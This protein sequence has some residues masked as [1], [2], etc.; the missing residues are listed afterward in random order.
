M[1]SI[2]RARETGDRRRGYALLDVVLAVALFALTV[3]GLVSV[4]QRIN[5]TSSTFARDRMI[6]NRLVS[7][8][9]ETKSLP[10]SAMTTEVYDEML[11]ITFRTTVEAYQ[12]DNGEGEELADLYQ[13]T[14]EA[15]F[16]DDGGEQVERAV[17][18]VHKPEGGR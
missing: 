2:L 1:R 16:L 11:A 5:E 15:Q 17:L 18:L 13:L 3:T 12:V 7:L 9:S 6:Q 14:A 4:M 8:L 10:V